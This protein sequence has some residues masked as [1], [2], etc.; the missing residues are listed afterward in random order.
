MSWSCG[1]LPCTGT[2]S[3]CMASTRSC[4]PSAVLPF[5]SCQQCP[6]LSI[7]LVRLYTEG[8]WCHSVSEAPKDE[9]QPFG[10]ARFW[11]SGRLCL[12]AP[13]LPS[14]KDSEEL[15]GLWNEEIKHPG[16]DLLRIAEIELLLHIKTLR[17]VKFSFRIARWTISNKAARFAWWMIDA[18]NDL[19][20]L[21]SANECCEIV[22][23]QK[24]EACLSQLLG[25]QNPN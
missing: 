24:G 6:P 7:A 22:Y 12:A 16:Y 1:G 4:Y 14:E 5:I 2:E 3:Q 23:I 9:S 10:S 11:L 17:T 18:R 25:L 19:A 13:S 21:L 20:N 15:Y 8:F